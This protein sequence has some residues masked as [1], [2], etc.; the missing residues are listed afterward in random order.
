MD[1]RRW[2]FYAEIH[3]NGRKEDGVYRCGSGVVTSYLPTD[4]PSWYNDLRDQIASHIG[5]S[6]S[7]TSNVQV[8]SL[9]PL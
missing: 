3:Y 5:A 8:M 6:S 7:S 1:E 9:T 4:D 2:H